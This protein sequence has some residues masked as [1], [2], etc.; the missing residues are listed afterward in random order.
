MASEKELGKHPRISFTRPLQSSTG[1]RLLGHRLTSTVAKLITT[2][3]GLPRLNPTQSYW[4][5]VPHPLANTQSA[6]LPSERDY[7]IIGSG[8]TGLAVAKTILENHPTAAVAILEART[9]CSGATGRNGGQMAANIGEEYMHLADVHGAEMA[10]KIAAFTFR[11]LEQMQELAE[12]FNAVGIC[13]MQ[14]VKR[15][16]VFLTDSSFEGFKK[17]VRRLEEDHPWLK[18]VYTILDKEKILKVC[19]IQ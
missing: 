4:Q 15:L 9:L 5:H 12:E 11:N 14:R 13:E 10:G 8:I 1:F 7:V 17:S 3:P 19:S 16:R 2:D 6:E 18:G